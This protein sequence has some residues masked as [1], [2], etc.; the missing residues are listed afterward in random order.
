MQRVAVAADESGIRQRPGR[1]VGDI[2]GDSVGEDGLHHDPLAIKRGRQIHIGRRDSQLSQL[3]SPQRSGEQQQAA[4]NSEFGSTWGRPWMRECVRVST[5]QRISGGRIAAWQCSAVV[6][7]S[8]TTAHQAAALAAFSFCCNRN[9]SSRDSG[10]G[11]AAATGIRHRF[12]SRSCGSSE[13]ARWAS[14]AAAYRS[15]TDRFPGCESRC[16]HSPESES[17][18]TGSGCFRRAHSRP[19]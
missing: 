6:A 5:G 9:I 8:V 7:A 2:A 3:R 11:G 17:E 19:L 18:R 10:L 14:A 12:G 1:L 4:N 16:H 13:L 15:A